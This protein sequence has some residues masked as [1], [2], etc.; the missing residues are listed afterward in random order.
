M[1]GIDNNSIFKNGGGEDN[2]FYF[3]QSEL[4]VRQFGANL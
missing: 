3:N 2:F 4:K 1:G